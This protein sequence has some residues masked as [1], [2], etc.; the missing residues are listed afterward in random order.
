MSDMNLGCEGFGFKR[1]GSHAKPPTKSVR[2]S[3]LVEQYRCKAYA[4]RS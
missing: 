3:P 2:V 1:Q 4:Y